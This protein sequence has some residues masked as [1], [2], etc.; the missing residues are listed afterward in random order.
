MKVCITSTG[1]DAEAHV[2]AR[3]GRA[4]YFFIFDTDTDAV[5]VIENTSS[6]NAQGAGIGAASLILDHGANY[7]LTGRLGPKASDALQGSGLQVIEGISSDNTVR[8]A[9]ENF[10][11]S[12]PS[13]ST[14]AGTGPG[15]SPTQGRQPGQAGGGAGRGM[16]QGGGR[17]MGGGRGGGMGRCGGGGGGRGM[18]G[19][20]RR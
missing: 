14:T 2:D 20:R 9:Y 17:G 18:G 5:E 12:G 16:G 6:G 13:G 15:A 8:Q 4:P 11:A 3:F 1:R 19:G 7:L 10:K